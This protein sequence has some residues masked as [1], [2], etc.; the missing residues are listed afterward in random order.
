MRL[1]ISWKESVGPSLDY[2]PFTAPINPIILDYWVVEF[3][4][5]VATLCAVC[6]AP[7]VRAARKAISDHW[8]PRRWVFAREKP[9]GWMPAKDKYPQPPSYEGE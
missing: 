3:G 1:W 5:G 6:E 8:R 7:S 9:D 2:R 4:K